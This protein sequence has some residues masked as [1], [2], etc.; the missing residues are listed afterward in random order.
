MNKKQEGHGQWQAVNTAGRKGRTKLL[1]NTKNTETFKK[2][3]ISQHLQIRTVN[4][5]LV[6]ILRS[7]IAKLA[8]K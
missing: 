4:I 5:C 6:Q 1:Y 3:H 7:A 8:I 2:L